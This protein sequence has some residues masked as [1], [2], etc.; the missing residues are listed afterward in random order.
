MPHGRWQGASSWPLLLVYTE[1][2]VG[3]IY[4]NELAFWDR[5]RCLQVHR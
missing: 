3:I 4:V 5:L 1:G 2:S